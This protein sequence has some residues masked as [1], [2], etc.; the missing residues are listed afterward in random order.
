MEQQVAARPIHADSRLLANLERRTL[1]KHADSFLVP[2]E[3]FWYEQ[4]LNLIWLG[5]N[6]WKVPE[7]EIM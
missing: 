5:E 1:C 7:E 6:S 4:H 3:Q 2:T